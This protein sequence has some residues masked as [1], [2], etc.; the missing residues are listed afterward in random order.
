M[1]KNNENVPVTVEEIQALRAEISLMHTALAH[2]VIVHAPSVKRVADLFV[3]KGLDSA[4]IEKLLAPLAGSTFEEDNEMLVAYVLE[5]L[6]T[7]LTVQDEVE[8]FEKKIQVL[9]GATGI[10]KTSLIGKLG[11]RYTYFLKNSYSVAFINF[12]EHKVG[13]VEQLTHYSDAMDIPILSLDKLFENEYDC[14][15]IDTAGS[16]GE[17]DSKLNELLEIIKNDSSYKVEISLVLCAT[18]KMRDLEKIFKIFSD[19]PLDNFIFTK[20]DETDDLSDMI[21]FLIKHEKPV[22]YL[23]IG[24]EIP[25]DLRVATKEYLLNQFM[26]DS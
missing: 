6:D 7:L 11:A 17:Y 5:E 13:A 8:N 16:M 10:G 19:L 24:Q 26:S 1:S 22:T 14:L 12:D 2:D 9:V 15:F 25:E 23:S 18:S 3:A 4:W 21:N 20:L